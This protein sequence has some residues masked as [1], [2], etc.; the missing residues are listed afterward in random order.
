MPKSSSRRRAVLSPKQRQLLAEILGNIAVAWFTVGVISPL[1]LANVN[2]DRI[3][4][5]VSAG[6]LLTVAF[7]LASLSIIGKKND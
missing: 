2:P 3:A 5:S 1:F 6:I 7:I 4:I